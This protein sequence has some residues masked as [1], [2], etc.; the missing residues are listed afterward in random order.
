MADIDAHSKAEGWG[1]GVRGVLL[2]RACLSFVVGH[3]PPGVRA[4][5][6]GGRL[7]PEALARALKRRRLASPSPGPGVYCAN[8]PDASVFSE[9]GYVA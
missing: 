6:N 4:A 8:S 3:L 1:D 7:T 2:W 5:V 9:S